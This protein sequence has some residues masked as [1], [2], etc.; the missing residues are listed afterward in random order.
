MKAMVIYSSKTG[1]TEKVAKA[2]AQQLGVDANNISQKPLIKNIDVLFIGSGMYAGK[3]SPE[4]LEFLKT[5]DKNDIPKVVLF[6]TCTSGENSM[7]DLKDVL[8]SKGIT[9]NTKSFVCKGQFLLFSRKHPDDADLQNAKN[10]AKEIA[11][12]NAEK[13]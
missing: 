7:T 1:H 5:L 8:T 11:K 6:S 12:Q 2:M 9:V 4:M 13:K 10:F 3:S